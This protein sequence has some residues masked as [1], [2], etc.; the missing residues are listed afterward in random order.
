MDRP[1]EL[2]IE[3]RT[4]DAILPLLADLERLRVRV[5]RDW[6]YLY[7]GDAGH[8]DG[9]TSYETRYLRTYAESPG[10]AVVV[11]LDGDRPVGASTC[12]PLAEETANII[13]PFAT[14]G[15]DLRHFCYFGESVL[16]PEYRGRGAGV[17]F[18]EQRETHARS[19]GTDCAFTCF[20]AV[21]RPADHPLRPPGYIPLDRFWRHR[22]YMKRPDLTCAMRWREVGARD[23][24]DHVLVFWV[25]SLT[26]AVLP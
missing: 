18:F 22:G 9:D 23:E 5:F 16:L 4:G 12:I 20:C 15:W 21:E 14:R 26:G 17:R 19:S 10:A 13:A 3:T 25:K 8:R 7:D 24:S 11:A 2:R 1:A 6:P